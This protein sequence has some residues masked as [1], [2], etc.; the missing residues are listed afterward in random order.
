MILP[1]EGAGGFSLP[2]KVPR[3]SVALATALSSIRS[4]KFLG[5]LLSRGENDTK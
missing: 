3:F 1:S 5:K 4:E 2:N